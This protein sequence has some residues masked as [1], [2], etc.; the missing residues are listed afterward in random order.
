MVWMES[1]ENSF[2]D[3]LLAVEMI[4]QPTQGNISL[5]GNLSHRGAMI[6]LL[7]KQVMGCLQD[8]KAGLFSPCR[9]WNSH[10]HITTYMNERPFIF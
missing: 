10:Y 6:A 1:Q 8:G 7:D 9:Q 2:E 4:V 5:P 3:T